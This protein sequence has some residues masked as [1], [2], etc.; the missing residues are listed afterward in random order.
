MKRLIGTAAVITGFGGILA[1]I[2]LLR[3]LLVSFYGNVVVCKSEEQ[4]TFYT[5]GVPAI[6]TPTPDIV[7]V[8]EFAHLSLLSHPEPQYVLIIS[9]GAGGL[10]NEVLKHDVKKIDYAELDPLL[11]EVV[12]KYSTELTEDEL[13]DPRV[14]IEHV[15]GRFFVKN[16]GSMYDVILVGLSNPSDLQVNR[17]FTKE[18]FEESA[19]RLRKGGIFAITLPGSLTYLSEELS[20]LNGCILAT[21]KSVYRYVRIIPGDFNLFLASNSPLS[22][23]SDVFASRFSERKLNVNLITPGHIEYKLDRSRLDWFRNSVSETAGINRDFLPLGF[24]YSLSYWNALFSPYM[25]GVFNWFGK[26]TLKKFAVLFSLLLAV[27]LSFRRR[28]SVWF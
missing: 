4:Y 6:T 14:N 10:I 18:F 1:Q 7:F 24:F 17:F 8:E 11:L 21:L 27:F 22:T 23:E 12:R 25:R 9:G 19:E 3:E 13:S 28:F 5:D 2:L 16:A 26:L 15:D 20:S